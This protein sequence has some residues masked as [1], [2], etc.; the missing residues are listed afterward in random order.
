MKIKGIER[1][2][3]NLFAVT[4]DDGTALN[5]N[6]AIFSEYGIRIDA[7]ISEDRLSEAVHASDFYRAKEK[8]LYLLDYKDYSYKEIFGKLEKNYP[9]D[10]CF[11]VADHLAQNG[12]INDRRYAENLIRRLAEAKKYGLYRIKSEMRI[13]GID[14]NI[15]EE[16]IY[17]YEDTYEDRLREI[18]EK[19]YAGRLTDKKSFDKACA[20][21]SRMGY[22]FTEIRNVL[23]E[24]FDPDE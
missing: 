16:L 3:G 12:F 6:S 1:L 24:Y 13:K 10:I 15:I 8:A 14:D 17:K 20:S 22:S 2:K 19:K 4:L 21:L 23:S 9:E 11:E 18:A 7:V 5:I